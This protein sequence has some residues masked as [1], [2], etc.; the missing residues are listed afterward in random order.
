MFC[1][2]LPLPEGNGMKRQK[3][4]EGIVGCKRAEGPNV[5][6]RRELKFR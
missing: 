1:F 3:S 6:E 5:N 4:A 2:K